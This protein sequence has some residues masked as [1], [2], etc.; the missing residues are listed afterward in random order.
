[1]P[2]GLRAFENRL[3]RRIFEDKREEVTRAWIAFK[4]VL[5]IKHY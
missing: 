5:F 2:Y 4:F 3:L 1:M